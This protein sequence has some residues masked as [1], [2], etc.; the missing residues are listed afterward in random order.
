M[1]DRGR[2]KAALQLA[3]QLSVQKIS[4]LKSP[5]YFPN[6]VIDVM[7]WD[8]SEEPQQPDLRRSTRLGSK[9]PGH[10]RHNSQ[11]NSQP[12]AELQQMQRRV[13]LL[14]GFCRTYFEL[15]QLVTAIDL[16]SRWRAEEEELFE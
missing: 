5:N 16:L 1:E 6:Q 4:E 12:S 9:R 13:E 7:E 3:E 15:T 2:I 10:S 14:R 11:A 8:G